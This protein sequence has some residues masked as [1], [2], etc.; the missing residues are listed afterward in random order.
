MVSL[1]CESA[2]AAEAGGE[3]GGAAMVSAGAGTAPELDPIPAFSVAPR[4]AAGSCAQEG[5]RQGWGKLFLQSTFS[6]SQTDR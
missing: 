3:G 5:L 2:V 6:F 1:C 4:G